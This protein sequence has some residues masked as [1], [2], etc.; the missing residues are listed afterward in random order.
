MMRLK[1]LILL[2]LFI[3]ASC[4]L[5]RQFEDDVKIKAD[6]SPHRN[7]PYPFL[8]QE[9]KHHQV[10]KELLHLSNK[11]APD[12][13]NTLLSGMTLVGHYWSEH[14]YLPNA[15][16]RSNEKLFVPGVTY[17]ILVFDKLMDVEKGK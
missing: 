12:N 2:T 3:V 15:I 14:P 4:E 8:K 9:N 17:Y 6:K 1:L 10:H 11:K 16:Y 5:L 7:R 13:E